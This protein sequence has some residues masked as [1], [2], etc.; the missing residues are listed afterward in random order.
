[1]TD[2]V[3]TGAETGAAILASKNAYG[4]DTVNIL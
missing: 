4:H 2:G 1:M 3:E